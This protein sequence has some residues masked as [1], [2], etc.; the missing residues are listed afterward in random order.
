VTPPAR[1]MPLIAFG[2]TGLHVT[3][4]GLGLAALG[5]PRYITLGRDHDLE[6]DRSIDEM[7]RRSHVVLDAA[8]D[9]GVRYVD[10]ARSYG[11]AESFL[12]SWLTTNP[13]GPSMTVGSK[14]GYTYVADWRDDAV[15]HEVKDHGAEAL[16][17]QVAESRAILGAALDLYQIHSATIDTGVLD[18][19][20][21]LATL[22]ALREE[23]LVIGLSTSGPAQA[24]TIRR[25]LGAEVDGRCP[26]G[27]VQS[28]WNVLEPS[29]ASALADAHAAGWGVIVKEVVA[30]GRL[31]PAA[32]ATDRK[33]LAPVE[34]IAVRHDAAIDQVAIAVALAQPWCHVVLSGAATTSQLRSHVGA[35]DLALSPDEVGELLAADRSS[36]IAERPNQYWTTRAALPWS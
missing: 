22:V 19:P 26:F 21:V 33:R 5:R 29:A 32:R 27:A 17:R 1:S 36:S 8:A 20:A 16:H 15:V 24:D 35:L 2:S 25:A 7:T 31:T 11:Y 13:V 23:G 3:R 6:D 18:D 12:A 34:R 4:I 28:T 14:W 9:L 30:N 10:V